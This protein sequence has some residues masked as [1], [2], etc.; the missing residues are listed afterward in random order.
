M[1]RFKKHLVGF[2]I[3]TCVCLPTRPL[4]AQE[5]SAAQKEVWANVETYWDLDAKR[6]LEKFMTYF[7]EDYLGWYNRSSVPRTKAE[8][9]PFI[10][11]DFRTTK[12]LVQMIKPIGIK[13]HGNIAFVHYHFV[14]TIKDAEGKEKALR[15]RWTD[16]LTKQGGKWVMIGDHGG[17][18]AGDK[19]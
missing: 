14:R 12:V 1:H 15:G 19:E 2:A 16:I 13:I 18:E 17:P 3:L 11:H 7:H 8:S 6:D 5:W 9:R 4:R 10:E